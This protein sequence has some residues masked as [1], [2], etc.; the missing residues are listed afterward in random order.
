MPDE[1]GFDH[2]REERRC[3]F[4]GCP[5]KGAVWEWPDE[6]RK[7]HFEQV[8]DGRAFSSAPTRRPANPEEGT[9]TDMG[10]PKVTSLEACIATIRAAGKPLTADEIA[11]SILEAKVVP[12]LK[13][14]TPKATLSAT[15]T[16][17]AKK[18]EIFKRV[19]TARPARF[20]LRKDADDIETPAELVNVLRDK[21][22]EVTKRADAKPPAARVKATA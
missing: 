7:Q 12:T 18:G 20:D 11:T 4:P 10:K 9:E 16:A 21:V 17:R 3:I 8:H 22:K 6:K 19:G 13:G 5:A 14:K 2:L 1:Y 15:V